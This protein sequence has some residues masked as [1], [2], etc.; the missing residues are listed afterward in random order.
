MTIIRAAFAA[1]IVLAAAAPAHAAPASQSIAVPTGDLELASA[2]GQRI[3]ARRVHR[4][5]KAVCAA[6]AVQQLPQHARAERR[7]I[8][9]TTTRV[10]DPAA[11]TP[12]LAAQ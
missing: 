6:E 2:E 5:A 1:A 8:A 4:A 11:A 9:E 12:K 3:L 7:C 10:Q